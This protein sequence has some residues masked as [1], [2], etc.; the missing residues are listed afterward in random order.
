M[1]EMTECGMRNV[2]DSAGNVHNSGG[3]VRD[4]RENVRD[5]GG[6]KDVLEN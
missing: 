6:I 4:S 5:S 3:N 2:C 1:T